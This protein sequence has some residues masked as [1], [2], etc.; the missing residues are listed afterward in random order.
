MPPTRTVVGPVFAKRTVIG[1]PTVR[2]LDVAVVELISIWPLARAEDPLPDS[3]RRVTVEARASLGMAARVTTEWSNSKTPLSTRVTLFTPGIV[4]ATPG[5]AL[6]I[7][8]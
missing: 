4:A 5:A 7:P 8:E 3:M 6:L 2:C 1:S